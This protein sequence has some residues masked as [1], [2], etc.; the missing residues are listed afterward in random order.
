MR[1]L[2]CVS[3]LHRIGWSKHCL[4]DYVQAFRGCPY[5]PLTSCLWQE[6][7]WRAIGFASKKNSSWPGANYSTAVLYSWDS[8]GIWSALLHRFKNKRKRI[9]IQVAITH[10]RM[11][12]NIVGYFRTLIIKHAH[13]GMRSPFRL[14]RLWWCSVSCRWRKLHSETASY[15]YKMVLCGEWREIQEKTKLF[16]RIRFWLHPLVTC[17]KNSRLAALTFLLEIPYSR[18]YL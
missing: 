6:L 18:W 2:F 15:C 7:R 8:F 1:L 4:D 10:I 3:A 14:W 16:W 9:T 11:V 13:Y 17:N 12:L 5:D